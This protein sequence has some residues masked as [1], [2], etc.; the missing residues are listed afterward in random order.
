LRKE[1]KIR[2]VTRATTLFSPGKK[3]KKSRRKGRGKRKEKER[4]GPSSVKTNTRRD[5]SGERGKKSKKGRGGGVLQE[6]GRFYPPTYRNSGEGEKKKTA[7]PGGGK[8]GAR[9]K[10][11][12]KR[13]R[14]RSSTEKKRGTR[15]SLR[16]GEEQF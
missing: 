10:E 11:R 3:K 1:G 4:A 14:G 15:N 9:A 6:E 13:S 5:L 12:K 8:G 2:H 16:G 7:F